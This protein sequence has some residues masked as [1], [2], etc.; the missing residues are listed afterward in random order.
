MAV[1]LMLALA[2]SARGHRA[3]WPALLALVCGLATLSKGF[4]LFL[5]PAAGWRLVGLPSPRHLLWLSALACA[6]ALAGAAWQLDGPLE[7]VAGLAGSLQYL[8]EGQLFG[9]GIGQAGNY[10]DSGAELGEE[11]GLGNAIAQVGVGALLPLLWVAAIAR[12]VLR[13]AAARRDPG[14]P[15]LAAW[16]LFW[17]VSYLFWASSLGA[18]GNALGFAVLALYLHPASGAGA[19]R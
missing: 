5:L 11:S 17:T 12:D 9:E 2:R 3:G 16:L 18:G 14:G 6:A 7:H 1:L 4:A 13:A 10:T 8:G 19:G 15:W